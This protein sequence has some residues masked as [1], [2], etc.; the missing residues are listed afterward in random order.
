MNYLD[1]QEGALL[2]AR[3]P[4]RK[5]SGRIEQSN[6][7]CN[8]LL[9][10][11]LGIEYSKIL[12]SIPDW[13]S[14]RPILMGSWARELLCPKSDLDMI[15]LGEEENVIRIV[16]ELNQSGYKL[17]YRIPQD[18]ND[19]SVG[20]QGK[21]LLNLIGAKVF[22]QNQ[23]A[24]AEILE[25]M[26][27]KIFAND[28]ML[29]LIKSIVQE[30]KSRV[31]NN[32]TVVHFLEPHLKQHP[33]CLR[34]IQLALDCVQLF[35]EKFCGHEHFSKVLCYYQDYFLTVRQRLHESDFGDVLAKEM[36]D[37]IAIWLG[38][39]DHKEFMKSLHR[40]IERSFF[41]TN[42]VLDRTVSSAQKIRK[43]DLLTQKKHTWTSAIRLLKSS[44]EI[45]DQYVVRQQL[46]QL[47]SL[48]PREQGFWLKRI[49]NSQLSPQHVS[50]F[51]QSR[52]VD[53]VIPEF[54]KLVGYVQHDQYHRYTA[55]QHIQEAIRWVCRIQKG[56]KV[57][58]D[59]SGLMRGLTGRD[60]TLLKLLAVFHDLGKGTGR[61]HERR[62]ME[63]L[64]T[65]VGHLGLN[66]SEQETLRCLVHGHLDLAAAAFRSN[67]QSPAVWQRLYENGIYG[68]RAQL[69]AIFT[70][71]DIMATH[72]DN[73]TPWKAKCLKGLY[74]NLRSEAFRKFS[75]LQHARI[76]GLNVSKDFFSQLD[77]LVIQSIPSK[78]MVADL[79]R[80]QKT[81]KNLPL[82]FYR[83]RSE[84][85]VRLHRKTDK[86]GILVEFLTHL[87]GVGAQLEHASVHTL[88]GIGVY[89]WFRIR[90]SLSIKTFQKRWTLVD[91]QSVRLPTS[92]FD[93]IQVDNL[94]RKH[95]VITLSGEDKAGMALL[96]AIEIHKLGLWIEGAQVHTWGLAVDDVFIVR[97][98]KDLSKAEVYRELKAGL[99]LEES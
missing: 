90:S 97:P 62:S 15:F 32:E 60:W 10:K 92:K 21:D 99:V 1:Q 29:P 34:D 49:F 84:L 81:K 57:L 71:A 7:F 89:D 51:F 23:V 83:K 85:W 48:G 82:K 65:V 27:E 11:E 55:D 43:S 50:S 76:K 72:P 79:L 59:L 66:K 39:R 56:E 80:A 44:H 5:P 45:V 14:S 36:Q 77:P 47:A 12:R 4:M 31:L 17:R 24:D 22:D 38:F 41:Y 9:S 6:I 68:K 58:H 93:R 3:P 37:E 54:V 73:W 28:R 20:V 94:D 75:G 63:I 67:P 13:Q 53:K 42:W 96:A 40:G 86:R 88:K 19:W 8:R 46:D 87:Y 64:G 26:K 78:W 91:P 33:G 35:P 95:W 25:R 74:D 2:K 69:L 30:R 70:V 18:M 61:N 98:P 52:V 16:T